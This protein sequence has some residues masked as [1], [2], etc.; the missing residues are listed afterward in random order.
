[1]K[2]NLIQTKPESL[3]NALDWARGILQESQ[4]S[5]FYGKISFHM[6]NGVIQRL[7]KEESLVPP[8]KQ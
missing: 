8:K 1:M 6:E 7:I 4:E 5:N 3:E 2:K